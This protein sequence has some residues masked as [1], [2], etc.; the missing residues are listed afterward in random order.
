MSQERFRLTLGSLE[1]TSLNERALEREET[2]CDK[3]HGKR[4]IRTFSQEQDVTWWSIFYFTSFHSLMGV[5]PQGSESPA[6]SRDSQY[7]LTTWISVKKSPLPFLPPP[8][9]QLRALLHTNRDFGLY[10]I[11]RL[12]TW[13]A[14]DSKDI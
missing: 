2:K 4:N 9:S 11:K 14:L 7:L 8:P 13:S 1:V 6:L 3:V 10:C 12:I 5:K